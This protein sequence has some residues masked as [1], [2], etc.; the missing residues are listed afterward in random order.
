[1]SKLKKRIVRAKERIQQNVAHHV[2]FDEFVYEGMKRLCVYAQNGKE[3]FHEIP[4]ED[5]SG[6]N[7][8]KLVS[9]VIK[10]IRR[11]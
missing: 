5:V 10:S 3:V 2:D 4:V 9:S 11:E 1:M 8:S 6:P 7:F